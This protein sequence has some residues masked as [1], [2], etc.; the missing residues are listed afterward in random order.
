MAAFD[1]PI[2]DGG[3]RDEPVPVERGRCGQPRGG[4]PA[5]AWRLAVGA[6]P[7]LPLSYQVD[8]GLTEFYGYA[9]PRRCIW[10][11]FA[12]FLFMAAMTAVVVALPPH[13]GWTGKAADEAVFGQK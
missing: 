13:R 3:I 4:C 7:F 2:G 1:V 11:G 10:T 6:G 12:A 5:A 8:D 9:V